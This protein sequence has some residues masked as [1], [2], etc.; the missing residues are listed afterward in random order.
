MTD[1]PRDVG[2]HRRRRNARTSGAIIASMAAVAI[3]AAVITV[4]NWP[5]GHP[6]R[7]DAAQLAASSSTPPTAADHTRN[8]PNSIGTGTVGTKSTQPKP[9]GEGQSSTTCP[10][11]SGTLTVAAAP[12]IAP[13]LRLVADRFPAATCSVT[14]V[15]QD[16][17]TFVGR[18]STGRQARPDVWVPNSSVWSARAARDGIPVNARYPTIASSPIVLAVTAPAAARVRAAAGSLSITTLVSTASALAIRTGLPNPEVSVESAGALLDVEASMP[19]KTDSHAALT[20]AV[21]STPAGLPTAGPALLSRMASTTDLAVPVSEHDVWQYNRARPAVPAVAVYPSSSA[22]RLDYPYVVVGTDPNVK[23][24]ADRFL[25][26]LGTPTSRQL[27][28][29]NGFRTSSGGAMAASPVAGL[30]LGAAVH[31]VTPSLT[32]VDDLIR[33]VGVVTKPSKLIAVIDVSGSMAQQV[34]GG[35]GKTRLQYAQAA[36]FRG[37]ALYPPDSLIGLWAFSR[38]LTPTTDYRQILPISPLASSGGDRG[39]ER[40]LSQAVS[41]LQ[42]DVDGGTGLYDTTLA[43]VRQLRAQ[44]DPNRINTVLILS[45]GQNDDLGSIDLPTLVAT[46]QQGQTTGKPV[47]I[48]AIAFGPDSDVGAMTQISDATGGATYVAR[49]PQDIGRIFL[50]AVGHRLCMSHC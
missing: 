38:N 15:D 47:P 7:S 24:F 8:S 48:I 41:S 13:A 11:P 20:F 49:N 3:V 39:G 21:R 17:A 26:E 22:E 10:L 27:L 16:P 12:D 29:R 14:I 30:E 40:R 5:V 42:V 43:A 45:D 32:T 37:L 50:D 9:I 28:M 44:W 34:P 25:D 19:D 35:G 23:A 2:R 46:L 4:T 1:T 33:D 36:A 31:L 6:E 18:W